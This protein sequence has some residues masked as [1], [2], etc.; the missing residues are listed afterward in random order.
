MSFI[1]H[2][3]VCIYLPRPS[4]A[5]AETGHGRSPSIARLPPIRRDRH[6]IGRMYVGMLQ[7][8][9]NSRLMLFASV[10]PIPPPADYAYHCHDIQHGLSRGTRA[11][12]TLCSSRLTNGS[13]DGDVCSA[14]LFSFQSKYSSPTWVEIGARGD[15]HGQMTVM[16]Q[17]HPC[18]SICYISRIS[19]PEL[20]W[21]H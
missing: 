9:G 10:D 20:K 13:P 7:R 4:Q 2:A 16:R 8:E 21:D 19:T 5:F 12:S 17:H 11:A 6:E 15:Q 1:E 18:S 3:A 14:C